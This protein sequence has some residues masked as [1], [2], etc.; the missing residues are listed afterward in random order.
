MRKSTLVLAVAATAVALATLAALATTP[1]YRLDRA[2]E[3]QQAL[4]AERPDDAAV[5]N[6]LGN[7]LVLDQDWQGAAAA[8]RRALELDPESAP[9]RFN[10]AL[11][12]QKLG[13]RRAAFRELRQVVELDPNHAWAHYEIG[14]IY[15]AWRAKPLAERAYARAFRLEPRLSDAR[16]NPHVLD[17]PLATRALLRA[18]RPEGEDLLPPRTYEE[19]AR[20]AA[21]M[22]EVPKSGDQLA[23]EPAAAGEGG[24]VRSLSGGEAPPSASAA[25]AEPAETAEAVESKRLTASDLEPGKGVNQVIG[26]AAVVGTPARGEPGGRRV[27]PAFSGRPAPAS[28]PVKPTGPGSSSP[29]TPGGFVPQV[30]STGRLEIQLLPAAG[31]RAIGA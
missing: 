1:P 26:G 29:P 12:L 23:A 3:V 6:D 24:F 15:Q 22:I 13:E 21:L 19:P 14:K 4:T 7:L 9:M 25:A 11:L 20:I 8:Y 2:I 28:E 30:D 31:A 18:H 5:F 27:R 17:N 16:V 10:Y